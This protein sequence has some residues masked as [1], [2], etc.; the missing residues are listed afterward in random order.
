[1]SAESPWRALKETK[2]PA[3]IGWLHTLGSQLLFLVA[4]QI[5]T[6]ITLA[7]VYAPSAD[8]AYASVAFIE[9]DLRGGSLVRALHYLGAS[10]FVVV[11]FLHLLRVFAW[12]AYK[13]PR[14]ALWRTG[15][16]IF[17]VVLAFAFTG[18]VLPWDLRGY[19]GTKVG[20]E[21][22]AS[23]PLVGDRLKQLIQGDTQLGGVTLS[24]FYA[25]HVAVLPLALVALVGL[26]VWHLRRVGITA[27]WDATTDEGTAART[28]PFFPVQAARDGVAV[29]GLATLL[30]VLAQ[31]VPAPLEAKADPTTTTHAASPEWYFFGLQQLLRLS[32]GKWTFVGGV[33]LPTLVAVALFFLPE[34]DRNPSRRL[35]DRPRALA[36]MAIGLVALAVLTVWGGVN[37]RRE[38]AAIAEIA[39]PATTS[40]GIAPIDS[41]LVARGEAL[42][43]ALAC[44]S[45]HDGASGRDANLPPR[46]DLEGSRAQF[47]WLVAYL[48]KPTP[49]RYL[50][51]DTRPT[52]RMP[53]FDL[54][55]DESR[56]LAAYLVGL[57]EP[58][59]VPDWRPSG[60]ATRQEGEK[61]FSQYQC[62]GCHRVGEQ[63]NRV[64]P[65]LTHTGAR[66]TPS[67][68]RSMIIAPD[69][70]VP[71]TAMK[72]NKL[73]DE[74]AD[75]IVIYL[76]EL[77]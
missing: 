51:E 73:W 11:L 13:P 37:V 24:R 6:G 15:L 57:R 62:L 43:K 72:D 4:T 25:I 77:K 30:L 75:A 67:Y 74:E 32:P 59:R 49:I 47:G 58:G 44:G 63:G 10:A 52:L 12:G 21:V 35:R 54:Q 76:M 29:L 19:F 22:A 23:T 68:M 48:E 66:L 36:S 16:A 53:S 2:L 46:L 55:A 1:V 39:A 14:A 41:A 3:G 45:C 60:R 31:L 8:N 50:A 28:T 34:L 71:G 5:A 38:R 61:L 33:L 7:L 18:Y 42:Y 9:R 69:R 26:H 70:V 27:P 56:A 40:R 64:G 65:D 20:I 17:G